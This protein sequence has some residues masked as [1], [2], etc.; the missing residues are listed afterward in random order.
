MRGTLFCYFLAVDARLGHKTSQFDVPALW[1]WRT[2]RKNILFF[3]LTK[4]GPFGF[5]PRKF[6]QNLTNKL[7]LNKIEE[8]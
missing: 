2:Q 4:H 3:F 8:V 1:S 6:R 5:N 7:R